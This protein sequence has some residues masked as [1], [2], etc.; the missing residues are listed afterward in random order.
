MKR[1]LLVL[2]SLLAASTASAQVLY[3]NVD[4]GEPLG[5]T[6]TWQN[7]AGN[8]S[9][10]LDG[11]TPANWD[12]AA[13]PRNQ[14]DFRGTAGSVTVSGGVTAQNLVVSSGGYSFSG[15]T[16]TLGRLTGS[17]TPFNL[18]NFTGDGLGGLT[19]SNNIVINDLETASSGDRLYVFRN[20][21]AGTLTLSG[22]I[23]IDYTGTSQTLGGI[24]LY[25]LTSTNPAGSIILEGNL[26]ASPVGTTSRL[27]VEGAEGT[28]ILRGDNT[29]LTHAT[30]A[31]I[32]TGNVL[33]ENANA[34]G[35][36]NV[37]L[38]VSS[39]SG[40]LEAKVLTNGALTIANN[41]NVGGGNTGLVFIGGNSAHD[42]T[43]SST[44]HLGANN[45]DRQAY[46]V[47]ET[48]GRVNFTGNVT[49]NSQ[50]ATGQT[51]LTISGGG[52][53]A[54]SRAE[55]NT[56]VRPTI[57]SEGTLILLNTSGS[58][59]GTTNGNVT[60]AAGAG[61]GGT[62]ITTQNVVA[63]GGSSI[64][65]PGDMTKE[66][67]SSI[68]TLFLSGGLTA[69]DGVTFN[70]DVN[71]TLI[72]QVDF[73]AGA[74]SLDNQIT[75]NINALGQMETGIVYS[76]FTGTGIWT[77]GG[78][79]EFVFNLPSGYAMD[80]AYGGGTGFI[81]DAS[82]NS[83]TMQVVPEPGTYALLLGLTVLAGVILRRR[84]ARRE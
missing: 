27:R 26:A 58:A 62:G 49:S 21:T 48:G 24:K 74:L 35:G 63:S 13:S 72:D 59:T 40:T 54:L 52:V 68:G 80:P 9:S 44:V 42:S 4:S 71:G 2:G 47:A 8:W 67:N 77:G 29:A 73:G 53:V 50:D 66:G 33:V 83:L 18:V 61:L 12:N 81:W 30:S 19:I 6:G 11:T 75:F 56:Y 5:G 64:I 32:V 34:L 14:A 37:Q 28:Y 60:I 39:T 55:G 23:S 70:Y 36:G 57:I 51:P 20:E 76:L 7:S 17:S 69:T 16:I 43:F 79:L 25:T 3:W 22:D 45:T 10:T 82:G 15:D 31:Q 78:E 46:L 41:I 84:F 38:G 1:L 65:T